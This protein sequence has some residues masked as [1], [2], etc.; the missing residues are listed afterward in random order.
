MT[1]PFRFRRTA[2]AS[3]PARACATLLLCTFAC[4]TLLAEV[5]RSRIV[6]P[7]GRTVQEIRFGNEPGSNRRRVRMLIVTNGPTS[8][9]TTL[10]TAV[11]DVNDWVDSNA[12]QPVFTEVIPSGTVF[13]AGG[14]C[15]RG[16]QLDFPFIDGNR[17][18]IL[19]IVGGNAIIVPVG[20]D[21]DLYDS[22]DCAV[23]GDGAR[24]FFIFTNRTLQRLFFY[25]DAGGAND[26]QNP[27]VTFSAVRSPFEGGLR[28]SIGSVP[29]TNDTVALLYM[30][31]N[32]QSRW[33]QYN[34]GLQNVEFNC[35]AG[36]QNPPPSGFTIPR[37][38]KVANREAIGDFNGD[39][40]FEVVRIA[41][42]PAAACAA[43][44]MQQTPAGP[45]AGTVFNWREP[46][47]ALDDETGQIN[48]LAGTYTHILA[49]GTTVSVPGAQTTGGSSAACTVGNTE[50][51]NQLMSAAALDAAQM[52]LQQERTDQPSKGKVVFKSG[53][54]ST[55]DLLDAVCS[56]IG[57]R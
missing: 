20:V 46:G 21:S 48:F 55:T 8:G 28:P 11:A 35:L 10:A 40:T 18:K 7:N 14:G 34:G 32:G 50:T 54:E 12:P 42:T 15:L 30:A 37:G 23:S 3:F 6:S 13:S 1:H 25:N 2:T 4:S 52:R 9:T 16:N 5:V 45:V 36:T 41:P 57:R 49:D 33:L 53:H 56:L 26:L 24:T 29:D 39:G 43:A 22:A 19:R 47:V 51:L 27:T 38:A 17:P 31:S 44:P